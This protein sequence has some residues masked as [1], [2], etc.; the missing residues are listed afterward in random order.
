MVE[1]KCSMVNFR[2]VISAPVRALIEI[3]RIINMQPIGN[4]AVMAHGTINNALMSDSLKI[5]KNQ[6][7]RIEIFLRFCAEQ[8]KRAKGLPRLRSL[9]NPIADYKEISLPETID[10]ILDWEDIASLDP[11]D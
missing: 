7:Q 2:I 1:A 11:T 5:L 3:M 6:E 8:R 4:I 10:E 9:L